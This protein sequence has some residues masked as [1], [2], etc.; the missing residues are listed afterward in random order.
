M[1]DR[2]DRFVTRWIAENISAK[3]YMAEGD[4]AE[5]A[6]L[7]GM[8]LDAAKVADISV[9]ELEDEFPDLLSYMASAIEEANDREAARLADEDR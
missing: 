1:S 2:A 3:G 9:S 8:C 5:A 6:S 7:A 4:Y